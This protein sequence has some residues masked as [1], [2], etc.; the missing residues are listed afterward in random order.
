MSQTKTKKIFNYERILAF[1]ALLLIC[2]SSFMSLYHQEEHDL[3]AEENT[4]G[5]E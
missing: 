4:G 3:I 5:N 2:T 1:L